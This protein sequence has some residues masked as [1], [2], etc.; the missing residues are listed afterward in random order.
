M[1]SMLGVG[2]AESPNKLISNFPKSSA[3]MM[4]MLGAVLEAGFRPER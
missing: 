1:A 2:T 3:R 4:M